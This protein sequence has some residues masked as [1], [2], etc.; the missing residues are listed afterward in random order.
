VSELSTPEDALSEARR[1]AEAA[2]A[3]GE[4][5][6]ADRLP[7]IGRPEPTD[8]GRLYEW[9]FIE[10]SPEEIR[11][12]RRFG[13]PITALKRLLGRLLRQHHIE[14]Q[15]QQ[16]RFNIETLVYVARLEQRVAE[17]ERRATRGDSS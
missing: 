9:A 2:R 4:Y 1:R 16:S 11:S 3:A 13:A 5:A 10:I 14:L 7:E 17:L 6:E 12:T 8:L 15:G